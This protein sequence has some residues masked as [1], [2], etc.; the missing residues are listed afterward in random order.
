[1]L[2]K[3]GLVAEFMKSENHRNNMKRDRS[4]S[5]RANTFWGDGGWYHTVATLYQP[6]GYFHLEVMWYA[7]ISFSQENATTLQVVRFRVSLDYPR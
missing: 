6:D 1:M 4:V 3:L 7:C 2:S 5:P